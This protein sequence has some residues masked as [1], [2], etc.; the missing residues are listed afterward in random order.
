[1]MWIYDLAEG[2]MHNTYHANYGS[3]SYLTIPTLTSTNLTP[4]EPLS[5]KIPSSHPCSSFCF[6]TR[7]SMYVLAFSYME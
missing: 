4:L 2:Y 7:H 1:M 3:F 6:E 5:D